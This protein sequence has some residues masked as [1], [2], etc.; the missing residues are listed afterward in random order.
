M[1]YACTTKATAS[2]DQS[3]SSSM[4]GRGL[5]NT[6]PSTLMRLLKSAVWWRTTC[7]FTGR[8]T[9]HHTVFTSPDLQPICMIS[10][11]AHGLLQQSLPCW[12]PRSVVLSSGAMLSCMGRTNCPSS[13]SWIRR[14]RNGKCLTGRTA[15][16]G[17]MTRRAWPTYSMQ[18]STWMPSPTA[19]RIAVLAS[20]PPQRS[21]NCLNTRRSYVI[22]S[23][24]APSWLIML[25]R[26][27]GHCFPASLCLASICM[28]RNLVASPL[29][30]VRQLLR[31]LVQIV[32][33]LLLKGVTIGCIWKNLIVSTSLSRIFCMS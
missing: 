16:R 22:P 20:L 28:G 32:A 15:Q 6:S 24:S 8:A 30:A 29:L 13:Y 14:P 7:V 1:A 19:T 9:S 11:Q 2:T 31:S 25:P 26:I 3:L 27:G 33:Q 12:E 17:S 21:W 4:A 10:S 5:Q 18:C 23:T